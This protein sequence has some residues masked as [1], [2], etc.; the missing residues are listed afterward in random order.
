[1]TDGNTVPDLRLTGRVAGRFHVREK[2]FVRERARRTR[3]WSVIERSRLQF[4]ACGTSVPLLDEEFTGRPRFGVGHVH[5]SPGPGLF[6]ES[7]HFVRMVHP[8]MVS[9]R[10]VAR[11]GAPRTE[12]TRRR[13][14]LESPHQQMASPGGEVSGLW[15]NLRGTRA[16]F[17]VGPRP[18]ARPPSTSPFRNPRPRSRPLGPFS[19]EGVL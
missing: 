8:D 15:G 5:S 9:C 19:N 14:V 18:R 16:L 11:K 1:M 17:A 2:W 12:G 6:E 3:S 10:F 13:H 7:P 4:G